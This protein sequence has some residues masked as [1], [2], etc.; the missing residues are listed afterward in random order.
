MHHQAKATYKR[1]RNVT[2]DPNSGSFTANSR[3][4]ILRRQCL[5]DTVDPRG[6]KAGAR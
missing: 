6:T 4:R 1:V 3:G 5:P 2:E